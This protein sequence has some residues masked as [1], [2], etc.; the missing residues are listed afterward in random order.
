M[1]ERLSDNRL[2]P[3]CIRLTCRLD[4]AKTADQPMQPYARQEACGD[5]EVAD[6]P[7]E[8]S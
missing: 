1:Q 5:G 6:L 8:T 2:G 4:A 7:S 3:T